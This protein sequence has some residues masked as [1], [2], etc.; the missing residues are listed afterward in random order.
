MPAIVRN[1]MKRN[2]ESLVLPSSTCSDCWA[3]DG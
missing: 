3:L 2:A 1:P